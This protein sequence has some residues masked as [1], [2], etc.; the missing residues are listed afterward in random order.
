MSSIEQYSNNYLSFQNVKDI[1]KR[2]NKNVNIDFF[3]FNFVNLNTAD[4][5]WRM[6][7]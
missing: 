5:D 2:R 3:L 1:V 7:T 6:K 4:K